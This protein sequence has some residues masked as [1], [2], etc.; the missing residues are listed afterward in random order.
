M[1]TDRKTDKT[2][3]QNTKQQHRNAQRPQMDE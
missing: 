2:N 1:P 3:R